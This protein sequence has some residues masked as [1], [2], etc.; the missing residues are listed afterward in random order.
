[1][2]KLNTGSSRTGVITHCVN[3]VEKRWFKATVFFHAVI[4]FDY[5]VKMSAGDL[6]SDCEIEDENYEDYYCAVDDELDFGELRK[7]PESFHY[8]CLRVEEVEKLL[9]E[10]VEMLSIQLK[11]SER[12]LVV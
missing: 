8:E 12:V 11:V 6:E 3:Y 1:M 5:R 4:L 9:N 10:L 2:K 7:D